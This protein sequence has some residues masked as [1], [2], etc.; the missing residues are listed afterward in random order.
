M[1]KSAFAAPSIMEVSA[2]ATDATLDEPFTLYKGF[3][4]AK[5]KGICKR[6]IKSDEKNRYIVFNLDFV[7]DFM[8][9]VIRFY[10]CK[11]RPE[12]VLTGVKI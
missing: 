12:M 4:L 1:F 7:I 2:G 8:G 10:R 11:Y 5:T 3:I 6:K 9:L